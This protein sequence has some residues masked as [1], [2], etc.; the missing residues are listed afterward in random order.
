MKQVSRVEYNL[1]KVIMGEIG[2]GVEIAT[3]SMSSSNRSVKVAELTG[4]G[5]TI[6]GRASKID[7]RPMEKS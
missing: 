2:G 7:K 3:V 6:W 4:L 1:G 5:P